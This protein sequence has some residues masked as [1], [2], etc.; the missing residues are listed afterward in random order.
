MRAWRS[1]S[2]VLASSSLVQ[3]VQKLP[4]G[5]KN[6]RA[7]LNRPQRMLP[8]MHSRTG[9]P[10]AVPHHLAI[11]VSQ[12]KLVFQLHELGRKAAGLEIGK[13][14]PVPQTYAD[15]FAARPLLEETRQAAN[16]F[17]G[18]VGVVQQAQQIS[19]LF[20]ARGGSALPR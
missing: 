7:G 16:Q 14:I 13:I 17:V 20:P 2:L 4:L 5:V 6:G 15:R 1:A 9:L 18:I 11:G 8:H 12:A 19:R 10:Q 3:L